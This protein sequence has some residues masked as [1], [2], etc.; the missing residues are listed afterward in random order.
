[1]GEGVCGVL[2]LAVLEKLAVVL[3]RGRLFARASA[4]GP[5]AR[6]LTVNVTLIAACP[7]VCA[8]VRVCVR[9]CACV[10]G[11]RGARQG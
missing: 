11:R 10:L 2:L 9:V 4:L 1:V 8:C 7:R 6:A 5:L 3:V